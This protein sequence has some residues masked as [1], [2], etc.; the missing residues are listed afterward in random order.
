MAPRVRLVDFLRKDMQQ[1]HLPPG[2]STIPAFAALKVEEDKAESEH[3]D[4]DVP[5]F[6][7]L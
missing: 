4:A 5:H 2:V 7:P 1:V 3:G 6:A